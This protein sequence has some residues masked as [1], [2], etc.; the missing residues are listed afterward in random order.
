MEMLNKSK[1]LESELSALKGKIGEEIS[2]KDAKINSLSQDLEAAQTALTECKDARTSDHKELRASVERPT[3]EH[4]EAILALNETKCSVSIQVGDKSLRLKKATKSLLGQAQ[5]QA[6]AETQ[7]AENKRLQAADDE[8]AGAV[9]LQDEQLAAV[10]AS[11]RKNRNAR[12]SLKKRLGQAEPQID[13]LQ[14]EITVKDE[15]QLSRYEKTIV[16]AQTEATE[17]RQSAEENA[18]A[19]VRLSD[20]KA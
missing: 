9:V 11:E 18:A 3:K 7:T 2:A 14:A 6:N 16:S 8:L 20:E 15:K 17:V 12:D 10:C 1:H 19:V 4:G 13:R 5:A